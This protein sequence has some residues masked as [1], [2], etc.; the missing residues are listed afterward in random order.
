MNKIT[1]DKMR[2][3]MMILSIFVSMT[4]IVAYYEWEDDLCT[5]II[6]FIQYMAIPT[7]VYF[8]F[9]SA[10]FLFRNYEKG[11]QRKINKKGK[12]VADSIFNLECYRLF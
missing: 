8:F 6:S 12:N 7:M 1:S 10:Y 11:I 9:A 5:S 2:W 3:I 4:H